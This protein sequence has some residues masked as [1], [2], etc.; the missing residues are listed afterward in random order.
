MAAYR[1]LVVQLRLAL[2]AKV[3]KI[4]AMQSIGSLPPCR[5]LLSA[6]NQQNINKCSNVARH[7][8]L[9]YLQPRK[10]VV[11]VAVSSSAVKQAAQIH[12]SSSSRRRKGLQSRIQDAKLPQNGT[13]TDQSLPSSSNG[14]V[15]RVDQP[16]GNYSP[17]KPGDPDMSQES[18]SSKQYDGPSRPTQPSFIASELNQNSTLGKQPAGPSR[19]LQSQFMDSG[20]SQNSASSTKPT[21]AGMRPQ[22]SF[23]PPHLFTA[24]RRGLQ[25]SNREHEGGPP[26]GSSVLDVS[27]SKPAAEHLKATLPPSELGLFEEKAEGVIQIGTSGLR[28]PLYGKSMQSIKEVGICSSRYTDT[29]RAACQTAWMLVPEDNASHAARSDELAPVELDCICLTCAEQ[30]LSPSEHNIW[31][32]TGNSG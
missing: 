12:S 6:D 15:R 30:S 7:L 24:K 21:R 29:C 16:S 25:Q 11:S 19:R 32:H 26:P 20:M 10:Q 2:P 8:T 5:H 3:P 22:P 9:E 27:R 1:A 13:N 18:N 23:L 31:H 17:H 28:I 4:S 14:A